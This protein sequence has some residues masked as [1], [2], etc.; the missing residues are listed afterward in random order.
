L[1]VLSKQKRVAA[2][3]SVAVLG[4]AITS[5]GRSGPSTPSGPSSSSAPAPSATTSAQAAGSFGSLTKVCAPGPGTGGSGRGI[6]GKTIRIGVLGDPGAA[7]APGLEQEFFDTADA[8][9]KWCNA[10]GGINGRTI[11]I[12]KLDAKLFN[13]AQE[14]LSACQNDFMLVGGANAL[15]AP[16]VKPRLACKLGQIPAYTVSPEATSAGLQVSPDASYPTTFPVGAL[17]LL[18]LA[19]PDTQQALGIAG[20]SLASLAPQGLR[21]Q[22][23]WQKLGF[24]VSTLQPRPAQV[25]NYRPYM[26]QMK[27]AGAKA[28]NEIVAQDPSPIFNAMNDTGFKPEWT[29]FGQTFY[30]PKSVQAAKAA[31]YFPNSYVNFFNLPFELADQYPVVQQ[32]K[33]I[34][35]ASNPN[36]G[37]DDNNPLG[38]NAWTLWA[39]SATACGTNL[40][41]DC[42]LQKAASHPDW[43]AGGLFAPVNTDPSV[44]QPSNCVLL[45]RLTKTGWVYDKKV[46]QP[47]TGPYNCGA[48]NLIA[49][50]SYASS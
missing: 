44:K 46:T 17:R 37:L 12:D 2:V 5:C 21:A 28:D 11:V 35:E 26:E 36:A 31:A 6:V 8:F 25:D 10:A 23:A 34:M 15:D 13:G 40:T 14:V 49:T 50:K 29:L 48:D 9:A 42:V 16:D 24:K 32:V 7:A 20:S 41:Q 19:Y 45:M 27:A 47:N 22:E 38:F 3:V 1:P 43:T 39:Q 33:D 4:L 18:A 30:S